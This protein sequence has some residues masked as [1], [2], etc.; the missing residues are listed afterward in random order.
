VENLLIPYRDVPSQAFR[1]QK[2]EC[3]KLK[4]IYTFP[5]PANRRSLA[6]TIAAGQKHR[7]KP[8]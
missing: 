4:D 7:A 8:F 6:A 3:E 2:P 5:I 1:I